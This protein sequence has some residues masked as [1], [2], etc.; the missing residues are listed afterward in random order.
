MRGIHMSLLRT[1]FILFFFI[2][3]AFSQSLGNIH[4]MIQHQQ[5]GEPISFA[6]IILIE[7]NQGTVADAVGNYSFENIEV[8]TYTLMVSH[9]GFQQFEKRIQIM[10]SHDETLDVL[11][12]EQPIHLD[13]I[14]VSAQGP[15]TLRSEIHS[16]ALGEKAPR[17]V[18]DFFKTIAGGARRKKG[19]LCSGSKPERLPA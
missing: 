17:D 3:T 5:T 9:I 15:G 12:V 14:L 4:G 18:G 16:R 11:L 19:G 7:S 10:A 6:Q 8:G 2:T 13:E 1:G